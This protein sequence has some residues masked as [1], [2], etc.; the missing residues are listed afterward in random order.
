MRNLEEEYEEEEEKKK[1]KTQKTAV[2]GVEKKR[3]WGSAAISKC[4]CTLLAAL[5]SDTTWDA[6]QRG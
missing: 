5:G 3:R 4:K 2:I 1:R 6:I